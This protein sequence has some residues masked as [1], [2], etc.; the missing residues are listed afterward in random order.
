M[1]TLIVVLLVILIAV[2]VYGIQRRP[3]A[4]AADSTAGS[5]SR[6]D[7]E[8]ALSE[9]HSRALTAMMAELRKERESLADESRKSQAESIRLA[10]ESIVKSGADQLGSKAEAIDVGLRAVADSVSQKLKDVDTAINNLRE[11]NSQQ[12][13]SVERAVEALTKRTD[14]L[15]DVLS[16]S[17]ARGQ[18]GER[19]AEDMLRAAGFVEGVNY[20]KQATIDSG[21]RPDFRFD[22]PPDRVLFMD[23]KF[24]LDKYSEFVG[25]TDDSVRSAARRS[26]V[27]AVR[28]HV[29][30]LA[31]RDYVNN[32]VDNTLDYVLMFVPNES[33]SGFVHESD[34]DLIDYALSKKV[35]MCSPLTLYAFLVV[36]RQAA[37]SFHTEKTAA[38][39]MQ[40]VNLFQKQWG[41]YTAAVDKVEKTFEK[42]LDQ[43]ASINTDG[44]RFKKLRAQV[45]KIEKLR[46]KQ[47]I[48]ELPGD[49]AEDA[50]AE[51]ADAGDE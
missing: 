13:G 39:I 41:E 9:A 43:I 11:M 8:A 6:A 1:N 5:V 3:S 25:A 15:N 7:L 22:I 45:K 47:G 30:T 33:I 35:V 24:P 10:T 31:R 14:N 2:V 29:D 26:F 17:Q 28:G 51:D 12:Y 37:D 23:V 21:G 27:V 46:T 38:E 49:P 16:N 50:D 20:E 42:L 18:W 32:S 44:T 40:Y 4:P 19:L 48:P 36:I 34:P